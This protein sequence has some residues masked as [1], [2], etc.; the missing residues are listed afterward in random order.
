M[1][2]GGEGFENF[3][4]FLLKDERVREEAVAEGVVGGAGFAF[5]GDGAGGSGGV[6]AVG[7]ESARRGGEIR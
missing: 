6:G 5:G 3:G 4:V 2:V 1:E 7:S